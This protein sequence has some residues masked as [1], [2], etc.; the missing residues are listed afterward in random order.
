MVGKAMKLAEISRGGNV[1][2]VKLKGRIWGSG[3]SEFR[4]WKGSGKENGEGS[5]SVEGELEE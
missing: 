2:R 1:N 4:K 5:A 3:H